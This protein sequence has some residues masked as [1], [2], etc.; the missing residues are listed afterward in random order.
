ML[1]GLRTYEWARCD[2]N[3]IFITH[4]KVVY[5]KWWLR[6]GVSENERKKTHTSSIDTR[7]QRFAR[8]YW[9]VVE[10]IRTRERWL[11]EPGSFVCNAFEMTSYKFGARIIIVE[12]IIMNGEQ[13]V[14]IRSLFLKHWL[15]R[16]SS[17]L[18]WFYITRRCIGHK[19]RS[20]IQ[21]FGYDSNIC[22]RKNEW[23]HFHTQIISL[24]LFSFSSVGCLL[25]SFL[26]LFCIRF[27]LEI[28]HVCFVTGRNAIE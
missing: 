3:L 14:L 11:R 15:D 28:F 13:M 20:L 24:K 7:V 27:A 25:F 8:P 2:D 6:D 23:G 9:N 21:Y 10:L 4:Q 17:Q 18:P 1:V 16:I 19:T 26:F 22:R 5:L 12:M